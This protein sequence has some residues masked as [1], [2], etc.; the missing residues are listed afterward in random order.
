[1]SLNILDLNCLNV[2]KIK[3]CTYKRKM[4]PNY[5]I[6]AKQFFFT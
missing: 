2:L 6:Y 1:M 3:V 5:Y 4:H